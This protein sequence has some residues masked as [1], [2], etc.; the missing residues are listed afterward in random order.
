L[1]GSPHFVWTATPGQ[2]GI[3]D[4]LALLYE[5]DRVVP[6]GPDEYS[7]VHFMTVDDG[8]LK[9]Y[10]VRIYGHHPTLGDTIYVEVDGVPRG[11]PP[12]RAA[13]I[14]TM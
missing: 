13:A 10:A 9:H 8:M 7:L 6:L 4:H 5:A 2:D 3:V 14:D 11:L 1:T 12:F